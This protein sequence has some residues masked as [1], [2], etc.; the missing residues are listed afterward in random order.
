MVARAARGS[1]PVYGINTG[2][3]KLATVASRRI[4]SRSCSGGVL[5]HM[6][7]LGPA[8]PDPVVRLVL[9]LK[10]TS[11]ALGYS[12]VRRRTI[13]LLLALLEHERCR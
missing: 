12:G 8:L 1:A 11:L 2:F 6:C 9:A 5:S 4:R 7:G 10:A 3:G 13:Q